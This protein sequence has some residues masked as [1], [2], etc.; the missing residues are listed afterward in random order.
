MSLAYD[1]PLALRPFGFVGRSI[2]DVVHYLGGMGLL[3][4]A[5]LR[6]IV[7]PRG[8]VAPLRPAVARHLDRILHFGLPLVAVIHVGLGSFLAMQAYFGATFVDGIG[9]VVGVGLI[10]NIAPLMSAMVLAG[11][12]AAQFTSEL[13]SLDRDR[14]E[15]DPDRVLDRQAAGDAPTETA[16]EPEQDLARLAAPRMIAAVLAG[17]V[18]GVWASL[19]GI[20]VGYGVAATV[21]KVGIPDFFD[22]FIQMLWVRDV[23]GVFIKGMLFGLVAAWFPCYEGL[24]KPLGES[25]EPGS[26]A[27]AA[28]RAACLAG[29]A[30]LVINSAWFLLL[31]HAG[32]A[33]GPTLMSPPLS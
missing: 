20:T 30:I 18:L 16:A 10:R 19:V 3:G 12:L 26:T 1:R 31:Y 32:P 11:L 5:V 8:E 27:E 7:R 17:P 6:S 2:L 15:L 13:R 21:L 22:M 28:L 4:F 9:P 23:V 14:L 25:V 24:R 33:F 29:V